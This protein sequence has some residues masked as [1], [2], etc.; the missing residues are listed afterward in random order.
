MITLG[1]F[2]HSLATKAGMNPDDADLKNFLLN[3]ELMKIQVPEGVEKGI[4]NQLI[5]VKDAK[6]NHQ[7][8]KNHY[9]K[10]ALD[11]IDKT[12]NDLLEE[13]GID[14]E[15]KTAVLGERSTYKRVPLLVS[16]IKELEAK[17]AAASGKGDKAEIQKQ[18]DDLHAQLK[19]ANENTEKIKKE[20]D[21][22]V[23][24]VELRYAV[25]SKLS[26]YK[27]IHDDLDPSV[28]RE[29]LKAI[30]NKELQDNKVQWA[31]DENGT[32]SLQ[33]EDGTSYY[34]DNHQLISPESFIEKTLSRNKLL[35]VSDQSSNGNGDNRNGHQQPRSGDGKTEKN[36]A[37]SGLVQ[38]S[39]K[40]LETNATT[41]VMG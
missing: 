15:V 21:Q 1:D 7:E 31:I 28:K 3:G 10:Q 30:I 26:P 32:L 25:D 38:N 34:G 12:I 22:K 40:N 27:T 33:K 6:N 29:I 36:H 23:K 13:L 2:L 35:K 41:A 8:I 24:Q 17:K 4:D 9:Q 19:Q 16:K 5:S 18:I 39:L 37:L 11:G 20:S 14:E